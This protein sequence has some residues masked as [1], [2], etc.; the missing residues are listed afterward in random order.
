MRKGSTLRCIPWVNNAAV[1]LAAATLSLCAVS[2]CFAQQ[3]SK[4]SDDLLD[5]RGSVYY[6]NAKPY[7]YDSIPKLKKAVHELHGLKPAASQKPLPLILS[8]TG[9]RLEA[10]VNKL[11]DLI[12][13]E[14]VVQFRAADNGS[15]AERLRHKY[16][17]LILVHHEIGQPIFEERRIDL[18]GR[19]ARAAGLEE[20]F[21]VTKGFATLWRNFLPIVQQESTF[22]YLGTQ[23]VNKRTVYV[24][25]FAQRPGWV[26]YPM[27]FVQNQRS[28]TCLFQG[29]AWIDKASFRIV[30]LRTDLLAPRPD[31]DLEK[32]TTVVTFGP[33]RIAQV[34]EPLWLPVKAEVTANIGGYFYKN[35]HRYSDYKL[36]RTQV[37]FL[38]PRKQ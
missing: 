37:R 3:S 19:S 12:A 38:P 18:N 20:G 10:L 27:Y 33:A 21:V 30:R 24:V 25:G 4:A 29:A 28:T 17:Y 22:R 16:N 5:T 34:S 8:Q 31:V 26:E 6:A 23:T 7:I 13:L 15:D 32:M 14:D 2:R 36:F 11:P 9:S 35:V 1:L